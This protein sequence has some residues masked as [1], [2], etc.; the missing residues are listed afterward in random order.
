MW[1]LCPS[2]RPSVVWYQRLNHLSDFH[3][4]QCRYCS[5]TLQGLCEIRENRLRDS[6]SLNK[7]VNEVLSAFSIILY[8]CGQ[9]SA[10]EVDTS[11]RYVA[12]T[13]VKIG[14]VKTTFY[15]GRK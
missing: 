5:K 12:V 3:E 15:D 11:S 2:V 6:L 10:Q 9:I 4:T 1:R 7:G 13:F 8:R 14:T